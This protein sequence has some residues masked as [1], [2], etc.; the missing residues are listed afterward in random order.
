MLRIALVT[1]MLPVPHDQTRGRYIH[2]TARSLGKLAERRYFFSEHWVV[3]ADG[4]RFCPTTGRKL[5]DIESTIAV[6]IGADKKD[7]FENEVCKFEK[8]AKPAENRG[9]TYKVAFK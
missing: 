4:K 7:L 2:E 6:R 9:F 5:G 8:A 3:E 1:P